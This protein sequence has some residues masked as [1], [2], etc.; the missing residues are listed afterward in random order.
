MSAV[1]RSLRPSTGEYASYYA[2]Y[3]EQVPEGDLLAVLERQR[4]ETLAL[5][6]ELPAD[7]QTHR[8]AAG[9]WSVK[10]LVGHVLDTERVFTY[11]ALRMARG[12]ATPLPGFDQ[13]VFVAG[14]DFDA[15]DWQGLLD[16]F[17][18]VRAST[19][20]LLGSL[21]E[22]NLVR[23]GRASDS[24]FTPRALFCVLTGHEVHHRRVLRE[25]YL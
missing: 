25:R 2:Q 18:S 21:S 1:A 24:P 14:A 11:R 3:V 23:E 10:E 20:S 5:L 12:D 22:E 9:K 15:R 8:Y 7:K 19:L 13:D 4:D 17:Q 6:A 16:E